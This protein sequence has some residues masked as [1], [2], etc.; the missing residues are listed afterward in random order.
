[1]LKRFQRRFVAITMALV[2]VVSAVAFA[3]LGV[4]TYSNLR[5]SVDQTLDNA[6]N[7][8][9]SY[10]ELPYLGGSDSR[11]N[12]LPSH[13]VTVTWDG[14]I[15]ADSGQSTQ[16]SAELLQS[17]VSA[18]L[19]QLD[20]NGYAKG[21]I[22]SSS[23]YFKVQPGKLGYR[24]AFVDG[25]SF[26]S[27]VHRLGL[28][29]AGAWVL[30]MLALFAITVFLSRYAAK[31][32]AEAWANQQRFIAD[33]SHE[34]KTP[35]TVILADTAILVQDPDKT[36]GEQGK[37]LEGISSEAERMRHLTEDLLALAQADAKQDEPPS[38]CRV[39]LSQL[40][41]RAVLQFEAA[42]FERGLMIEEDIEPQVEVMGLPDKLEGML[43]TLLENAC[44]YGAGYGQP[45]GVSLKRQHGSAVLA[46][47]NGGE[48][49][50]AQD[51]PHVFERFY[52][53]DRSRAQSGESASFGLGLAIAKATAELCKG[54]I[55]AESGEDGTVFT[56]TLPLARS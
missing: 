22:S 56:V 34:L 12:W 48:P 32:V 21:R 43:K 49:I 53:S 35:L 30:L 45:I 33:A 54:G 28:T 15:Y 10:T 38:L 40:T 50:P 16:M 6:L 14:S 52:R 25:S 26:E 7:Y 3:A 39:D 42:A 11:G 44:K 31:P 23:L 51:L 19:T 36:V 27:S 47:R 18:A 41:Q 13:S 46:V 24:V 17:A 8:G 29:L 9:G 20:A 4:L 37:W 55:A 1:M 2:L 5:S